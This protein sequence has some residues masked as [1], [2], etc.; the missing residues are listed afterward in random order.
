MNEGTRSDNGLA[1]AI[2]INPNDP[3]VIFQGTAGGG[4]WRS[5]DGGTTWFPQFDRQASLGIGEPGA[6]AID[7]NDT[8]TIYVGTSARVAQQVQA[9]LYK[10]TD[11]G[12][13]CVRLGSGY[14]ASNVGNASQFVNQW[15]NV[16]IV[17]P[18]NSQ[19]V[20]LASS[21]GVLRSTDGGLNWTEGAGIAGDVRSLVLD[22]SSPTAN[23]ILHAGS[24]RQGV[25]TSTDGG[26]NWT[27]ILSTATAVVATAVGPAPNGIGKVIVDIAPPTTPPN[28]N[29]VQV[30]YVSM[31]GTSGAPDP[32][33]LFL[34][35]DRGANWVQ[36]TA[37]GMPTGTQG[38]YS[39][40][41][42]VDPASPGDGVNDIL[43][44]GTVGQARSTDS[45][46][47][48]AGVNGLHADTHAWAFVPPSG[49]TPTRVY[50]GNDGGIFVAADGVNF[51]SLNG[52]GL[53]TGL[54]YNIDSRPDATAS[55]IVGALQD[56]E[57]QT[58]SGAA[59]PAWMGTNGGDGWDAVYDGGI[60]GQVYW[61]ESVCVSPRA[62]STGI[63]K[64][65]RRL[66]VELNASSMLRHVSSRP[67]TQV[68]L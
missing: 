55:V 38:S 31:A 53:Q 68:G 9:G 36:Q 14:P 54:F 5:N 27:Q 33:G 12:N 25:F 21:S 20:Y 62:R 65:S 15:I 37:S 8:D 40:H 48:F 13:S 35:T 52:G 26:Q 44:F 58:T 19:T 50:S 30:M 51:T 43:Y 16:I 47:N 4:V 3:N 6:L 49:G 1:S 41:F 18:A 7:P 23:R 24:S 39:F 28:P 63:V 32:V 57:V 67:A 46:Q 45:G 42:A 66:N 60:A 59:A 61:R 22:P 34:S 29:G 2:A 11:G 64:A 10:S 17:D 56:N